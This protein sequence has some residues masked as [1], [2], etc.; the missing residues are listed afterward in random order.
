MTLSFL[1]RLRPRRD[2][3][4]NPVFEGLA[5]VRAYWEGLRE[6]GQLPQRAALDPRGLGG[7]LDRVFLGERV[8]RGL[9]QLRI[10]G[11]GLADFAGLD[12]RG[13]PLSCLFTPESRAILAQS[14][15]NVFDTPAVAEID[16]GS[17]RL[18]GG[19]LLARLLLMPLSDQGGQKLVLGAIS[20]ATATRACKLQILARRE[21][22]L[23]ISGTAAVPAPAPQPIRRLGHLALVHSAD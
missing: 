12:V 8:G 20:F 16:L 15:E 17:D 4:R 11:S 22:T 14:M 19:A 23:V 7:V 9:V 13:L 18:G 3:P 21:E 5:Q 10:A 6:G 2:P 1:D